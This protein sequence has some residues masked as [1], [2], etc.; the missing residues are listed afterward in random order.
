MKLSDL[1]KKYALRNLPSKHLTENYSSTKSGLLS[2][3]TDP[4][5]SVSTVAVAEVHIQNLLLD[6]VKESLIKS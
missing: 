5:A 6:E 2:K 4:V 3:E 1:M